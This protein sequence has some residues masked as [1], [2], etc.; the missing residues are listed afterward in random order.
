[1]KPKFAL[2]PLLFWLGIFAWPML[3]AQAAPTSDDQLLQA[4]ES[5]LKAKDKA[6]ILALFNWDGVPSWA[7]DNQSDDIDDWLTRELKSAKLSPVPTN[8]PA[9]FESGNL[10]FKLNVEATSI[11]E[12]GFTDGFG[13]GFPSGKKGD[14]FYI[15]STITEEIAAAPADPNDLVIQVRTPDGQPLPHV[16]VVSENPG[17]SCVLHFRKLYGDEVLT[18]SDGQLHLSPADTNHCLVAANGRGFG[19]LPSAALTN[20][21]VMILQPWGRIEGQLENRNQVSTNI[22]LE[23]AINRDA[24]E[25]E[26][27]L[28]PIRLADEELNTDAQGRF[29]FEHVPPM[30]LRINRHDAQTQSGVYV[31]SVS[32]QPGETNRLGINTRGR[33]VTGHVAAGPGVDTKLNLADCSAGL[34][35]VTKGPDGVQR[36]VPFQTSSNGELRAAMVEPGDYQ[37]YGDIRNEGEKVALLDSPVVHV[38]DDRSEGPGAPWDFGAVTLKSAVHLKPGDRAPDF[39][40]SDLDGKPLK[41][42]DYRGKYVLLDFWATWCGPCVGETPN[43]K[44]TYDAFG[45][46]A[47]F[48]M[49]SLSLDKE[50]TAP[51]KFARRHDI[52]WRQGFLGDWSGDRVTGTYGVYGIPAI[53]LIGPDGKIVATQLRGTNILAAVGRAL[54]H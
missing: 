50:A 25:A 33:T 17:Q 34:T 20:H 52:A 32:I 11:I 27:V 23:L 54:A 8:I 47:Q 29:V 40:I 28:L 7:K 21:A 9:V 12:L 49:I 24:Y 48:A 46:D 16:A 36:T 18:D 37:I 4:L 5:A 22:H 19:W 3:P 42:S 53:F 10:R 1:M 39:A 35:A 15:A 45:S 41:L 30:K 31:C 51:Q 13:F 43:M 38:P 2:V 44:A 26:G 6:A 14:G